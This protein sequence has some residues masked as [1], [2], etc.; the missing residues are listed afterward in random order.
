MCLLALLLLS[1]CVNSGSNNDLRGCAAV[2]STT[3]NLRPIFQFGRLLMSRFYHRGKHKTLFTFSKGPK[4]LGYKHSGL[5][6]N[7]ILYLYC[8]KVQQLRLMI[9]LVFF[10][11]WCWK[12]KFNDIMFFRPPFINGRPQDSD[13]VFWK[14]KPL[15]PVFEEFSPVFFICIIFKKE[16]QGVTR[17]YQGETGETGGDH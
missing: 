13:S 7:K 10:S 6:T 9:W 14:K 11:K 16:S 1:S 3:T 2:A 5:I 8:E 17:S 12:F 15:T 4:R